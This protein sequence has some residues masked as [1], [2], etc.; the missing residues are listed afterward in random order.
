MKRW[1]ML[2]PRLALVGM[3]CWLAM[4]LGPSQAVAG[5]LDPA[6]L[7]EDAKWVVHVDFEQWHE[8]VLAKKLEEK[9]PRM[10]KGARAWL[11]QEYGIEPK[12]DLFGMTMFS[13]TYKSHTGTVILFAKFD[14]EKVVEKLE[15]EG[16]YEKTSWND[17]T[18]YTKEKHGK[19]AAT[20]LLDGDKTIVA[21][22]V[23]RAKAAV[24]LLKGE[25]KSM[26]GKDSPLIGNV[27]AGSVVYGA[28]VDL[29]SIAEHDGV[30]PIL[31]QHEQVVYAVG[32]DGD[33]VFEQIELTA[34]SE[35]TA[36]AMQKVLEGFVALGCVWAADDEGLQKVMK[37]V[38]VSREGKLV[39]S[40][41]RGS[42]ED[43]SAALSEFGKRVEQWKEMKKKHH[44][45]KEKYDHQKKDK[46]KEKSKDD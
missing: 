20:I 17:L 9:K 28:A 33:E 14:R 24:Q 37:D 12:E 19:K 31:R 1:N 26:K 21:S 34:A 27:P 41:Y 16:D 15:K 29:K 7:P 30:F 8:T 43:V 32:N 18:V 4:L 2:A 5:P 22:S 25:A 44:K 40:R 38:K 36:E 23:D 45:D 13:D 46:H 3:A 6:H 39:A 11:K 35:E 42:T 10:M